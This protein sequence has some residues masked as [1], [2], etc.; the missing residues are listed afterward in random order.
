MRKDPRRLAKVNQISYKHPAHEVQAF[1][2]RAAITLASDV[3]IYP[4]YPH[5]FYAVCGAIDRVWI[6][7]KYRDRL[8]LVSIQPIRGFNLDG[9]FIFNIDDGLRCPF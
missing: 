7:E 6:F 8:A 5:G 3:W 2:E 9:S 4:N 1:F